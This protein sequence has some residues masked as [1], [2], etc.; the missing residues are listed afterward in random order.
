MYKSVYELS[1]DQMS[2]LKWNA[3]YGDFVDDERL[4]EYDSPYDIPDSLIY[5]LYCYYS[6]VNDDFGCSAGLE[7]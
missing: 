4:Q 7:D 5:D 1:H 6:F 3:F 2:E